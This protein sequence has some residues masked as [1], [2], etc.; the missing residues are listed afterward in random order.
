MKIALPFAYKVS[1]KLPRNRNPVDRHPCRFIEAD[2]PVVPSELAP[3][4]V[5]W[6]EKGYLYG[7][8]T[9]MEVRYHEGDFYRPLVSDYLV[10]APPTSVATLAAYENPD[11]AVGLTSVFCCDRR[12]LPI[13]QAMRYAANGHLASK[14]NDR[15]IERNAEILSSELEEAVSGLEAAL[16][17]Y[18]VI[19]GG[20]WRKVS[21]PVLALDKV[22][23]SAGVT[24][25]PAEA[26]AKWQANRRWLTIKGSDMTKTFRLDQSDILRDFISVWEETEG[27]FN[28]CE[29]AVHDIEVLMPDTLLF[30]PAINEVSRQVSECLRLTRGSVDAFDLKPFFDEAEQHSLAFQADGDPAHLASALPAVQAL[31]A[32]L[33][34]YIAAEQ[35]AALE[36]L[37]ALQDN[38]PISIEIDQL[39]SPLSSR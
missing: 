18:I 9:A 10:S 23:G 20:L 22:T 14:L 8:L 19:D 2:I 33:E 7:G 32:A 4:A 6:R 15:D 37:F 34:N 11:V 1:V 5:R 30:E 26:G 25:E 29:V 21:E 28:H 24:T 12:T 35:S 16:S 13:A 17:D 39:A 31:Y 36:A 3:I 38:L 27:L